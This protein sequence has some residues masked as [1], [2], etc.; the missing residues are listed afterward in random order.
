MNRKK[1]RNSPKTILRKTR[2][3]FNNFCSMINFGFSRKVGLG[4]TLLMLFKDVKCRPFHSLF[5]SFSVQTNN[6]QW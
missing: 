4:K 3:F 6:C 2:L 5:F 1:L